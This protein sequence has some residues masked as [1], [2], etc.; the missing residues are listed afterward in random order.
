MLIYSDKPNLFIIS[1]Q[2]QIC[3]NN[4]LIRGLYRRIL[5]EAGC[6]GNYSKKSREAGYFT[7][8]FYGA[9]SGIRTQGLHIRSVLLYPAELMAHI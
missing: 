9:P 8:F 3:K 4:S 2:R 6:P 1:D 7:G 5:P